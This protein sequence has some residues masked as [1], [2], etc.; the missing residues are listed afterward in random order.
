M[1]ASSWPLYS[2][3]TLDDFRI[4]DRALSD[5]EVKALYEF[6]KAN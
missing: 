3:G 4:Y 6:E 5:A 2:G 1:G